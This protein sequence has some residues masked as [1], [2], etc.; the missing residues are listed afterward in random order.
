ML[1]KCLE[2]DELDFMQLSWLNKL[3]KW[4]S[5]VRGGHCM[6]NEGAVWKELRK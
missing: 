1:V 3:K 5:F 2:R 6:L 4:N